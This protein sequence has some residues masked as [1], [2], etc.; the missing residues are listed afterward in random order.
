ML[1]YL[2]EDVR[3]GLAVA[4]KRKLKSQSRLSVRVGETDFQLLRYWD[5]GFALDSDDAPNLRGLVDVYDGSR[6]VSQCLIIA[7][8]EEAGEM[9]YEFKRV[10]LAS[11]M[12]PLDYER[13]EN[14]PVAL[15][16]K[17]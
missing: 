16:T 10:T 2:P 11:D 14:A 4:R 12:A 7:S 5:V 3:A 6:H 17:T 15:M 1:E 13:D 9:I 8:S